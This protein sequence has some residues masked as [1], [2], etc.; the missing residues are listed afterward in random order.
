M[1]TAE[2]IILASFHF[3]DDIQHRHCNRKEVF[4]GQQT[5]LRTTFSTPLT[6]IV[7]FCHLAE[8]PGASGAFV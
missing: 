7:L 4:V 6:E 3:I 8:G 2:N 5:A 1:T